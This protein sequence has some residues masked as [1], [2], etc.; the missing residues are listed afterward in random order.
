MNDAKHTP[1]PWGYTPYQRGTLNLTTSKT[2]EM[3]FAGFS[4]TAVEPKMFGGTRVFESNESMTEADAAFIVQACNA[5][6]EL[7]A[8]TEQI[9]DGM[10]HAEIAYL[11]P[12]WIRDARA[13]LAKVRP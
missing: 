11:F 6:A 10:E 8:L 2:S 5:H 3:Q 12:A 9:I 4:I 1:T 13:A 7:V